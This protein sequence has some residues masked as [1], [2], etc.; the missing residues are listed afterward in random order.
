MRRRERE[1][2]KKGYS[3]IFFYNNWFLI[4]ILVIIECECEFNVYTLKKKKQFSL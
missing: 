3:L 2:L 4:E 1:N